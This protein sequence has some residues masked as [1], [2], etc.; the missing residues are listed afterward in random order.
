MAYSFGPRRSAVTS[1][2]IFLI[3][4]A[5]LTSYPGSGSTVY[6]LSGIGNNM[7]L[8][9]GPAYSTDGGGSISFDGTDDYASMPVN[10]RTKDTGN[11]FTVCAWIKRTG[12]NTPNGYV[13]LWNIWN[14]GNQY[15]PQANYRLYIS[16]LLNTIYDSNGGVN[17]QGSNGSYGYFTPAPTVLIPDISNAEM[18]YKWA[19]WCMTLN[20]TS[21]IFKGY[22]NGVTIGSFVMNSFSWVNNNANTITFGSNFNTGNSDQ[23]TGNLGPMMVYDRVLSDI[24]IAQNYYAYK[25]RFGL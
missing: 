2:S 5:N 17:V 19:F 16:Y 10:T 13:E 6:D 7:T 22:K 14:T 21:L 20:R 15:S 18:R 25:S 3:D 24:E 23:F 12:G 4:P 9:N 1:G 11:F 8:Q